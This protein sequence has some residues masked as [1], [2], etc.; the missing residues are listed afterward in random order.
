LPQSAWDAA[1]G[2]SA[3]SAR[4]PGGHRDLARVRPGADDALVEGH[5]GA[6]QR[7]ERHRAGEVGDPAG[8]L[9]VEHGERADRGHVLGAVQERQALLGL[10]RH[11]RQAGGGQRGRGGLADA[12]VLDLALADQAERQVGQRREIAGR[13]DRA[14]ARDQRVD[15]GGEHR[16]QLIGDDGAGAAAAGREH[17][18][19]Q[20]HHRAGRVRGSGSPTP[21]AWERT[22]LTCSWRT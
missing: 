17:R 6:L 22:R 10:E 16:A 2:E 18:G 11:R 14:A 15:P 12:A 5:D 20:Q 3:S 7:L 9:G 19:A 13:A 21:A 1:I 8:G 4:R